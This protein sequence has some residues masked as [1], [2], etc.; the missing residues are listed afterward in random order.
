[1]LVSEFGPEQARRAEFSMGAVNPHRTAHDARKRA[2]TI[3]AEADTLRGLSVG[4]AARRIE[5]KRAEQEQTRQQ[6]AQRARQLDPFS[7]EA[8]H[9]NDPRRDG[10]TRSL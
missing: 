3:R 10:P 9:R 6:E 1:M 4:D 8:H 7:H 2:A 5:A